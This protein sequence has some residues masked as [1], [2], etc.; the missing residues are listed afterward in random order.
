MNTVIIRGRLASD[1]RHF[2]AGESNERVN[3]RV[4][5]NEQ[6]GGQ[7]ITQGIDV[8]LFG[9]G[10][11]TVATYKSKGD[12]VLVKGRLDG[13]QRDVVIDGNPVKLT[14]HSVIADSFGGVEF[15]GPRRDA[16]QD[17]AGEGSQA[18]APAQ[19][20]AEEVPF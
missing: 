14:Q 19:V 16:N 8:T 3:L 1:P 6:R 18:P 9:K 2:N 13:R 7:E 20:P 4:L 5:W 17:A 10:A 11:S 12:E 15:I